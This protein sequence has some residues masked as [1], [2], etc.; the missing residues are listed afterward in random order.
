MFA[1]GAF[2]NNKKEPLCFW[3]KT[4]FY[5]FALDVSVLRN[6]GKHDKNFNQLQGHMRVI[7]NF[8]FEYCFRT[9]Q[10]HGPFH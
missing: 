8:K 5:M 1:N 9:Q 3:Y 4:I 2:E 10:V 6:V 7:Y